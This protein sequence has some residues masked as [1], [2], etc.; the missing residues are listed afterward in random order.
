MNRASG[1]YE[2]ITEES[3]FMSTQSQKKSRKEGGWKVVW[4]CI[5]WKCPKFG[6]RH[7]PVIP[8][9]WVNTEQ[10]KHKE[11]HAKDTP[12]LKFLKNKHKK[13]LENN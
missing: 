3:S 12:Q 4:R 11:I 5:G 9:S 6:K 7:K 10:D 13:I 2:T 1:T 8:R